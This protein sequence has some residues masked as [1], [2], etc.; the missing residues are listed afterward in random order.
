MH[1]YTN[2]AF[3]CRIGQ[4]V[5]TWG[6][7]FKH[8]EDPS[9][10]Q[11]DSLLA[12]SRA[13]I[14]LEKNNEKIILKKDNPQTWI[15]FNAIAQGYSTDLI[16][17]WLAEQGIKNYLV[18]I[19]GEVIAHGNKPNGDSW[20]VGV[21][22]PATDKYSAPEIEN[23]IQLNNQSV[24]TSGNY[25]KY[26]EKDGVRYSHT[27]DPNT[28]YPVKHSLLS[29]SVIDS[30]SWRADAL[31]TAFMVM[32][33]DKSLEFINTHP[34]PTAAFFI[35]DSNGVYKTYATTEFQKLIIQK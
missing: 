13:S 19:G 26:L 11:I 15:D 31:A 16:A 22:R 7:S 14:H 32:G 27:I 12:C 30:T 17:S 28:G 29:A 3:D 24:V 1:E 34:Y 35:Y 20:K 23:I 6:F 25:R 5:A 21:E 9:Q 8:N 18:D 4:L 2:G 33:L 10:K